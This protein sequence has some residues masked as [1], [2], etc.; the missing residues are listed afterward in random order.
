MDVLLDFHGNRRDGILRIEK[1]ATKKQLALDE[2][3]LVFAESNA[4]EEHLA[5]VMVSI[6]AL[7]KG[8]LREITSLMKNGASS[9]GAVLTLVKER[10]TLEKGR[11]EQAI[12]ILSSM[13]GWDD[14]ELRFYPGRRLVEA[15][16]N[17]QL[18]LPEL[19]LLSVRRAISRRILP[20]PPDFTEARLSSAASLPVP[21]EYP[22]GESES[23]ALARLGAGAKA[24]GVRAAGARAIDVLSLVPEKEDW[25][26]EALYSLH[27]LGLVQRVNDQGDSAGSEASQALTRRLEEMIPIVSS[28]DLYRILSVPITASQDQIQSAYHELARQ[29]H[30]DRFQSNAFSPEVRDD[31]ERVFTKINEAY[32]TLRSA[33]AR[34]LYDAEHSKMSP[35]QNRAEPKAAKPEDTAEALFA[36]GRRALANREYAAAV[37]RLKAAVWLCPNKASYNHLLGVAEGEMPNLRK[38]AEQH[39][40]KAIEL[41]GVAVNS[42][43][44]LAKLYIKVSL[45]RKAE[46]QLEQV[47]RWDPGNPEA[48]GLLAELRRGH[49]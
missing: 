17:L 16:M 45:R 29:L 3:R 5:R 31:A 44:E 41:E 15:Q 30:P 48:S 19:I 28:G 7:A 25:G 2:G 1:G 9:E 27:L 46:L 23:L 40:L 4:P 43:L 22:L 8:Q 49:R 42:H 38:S 34:S 11:R 35:A 47:L 20:I 37:D 14:C 21:V 13:L 10:E 36:D 6:A 12:V 33:A 26:I 39:L 24:A 32:L 18:P